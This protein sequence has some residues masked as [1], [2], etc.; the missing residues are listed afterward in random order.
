MIGILEAIKAL[1]KASWPLLS[2]RLEA[3]GQ[4]LEAWKTAWGLKNLLWGALGDV[5]EPP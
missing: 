5:L 1:L 4:K 3:A 2:A